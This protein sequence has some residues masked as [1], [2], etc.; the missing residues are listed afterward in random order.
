MASTSLH[1]PVANTRTQA[2][3]MGSTPILLSHTSSSSPTHV[4]T[5]P[6]SQPDNRSYSLSATTS[7]ISDESQQD[8]TQLIPLLTNVMTAPAP[9]PSSPQLMPPLPDIVTAPAPQPCSPGQMPSSLSGYTEKND[10]HFVPLKYDPLDWPTP[11]DVSND[12]H[13][14]HPDSFLPTNLGL[15]KEILHLQSRTLLDHNALD[16]FQHG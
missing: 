13:S 5:L 14:H 16:N 2:V 15:P 9:Q 7:P 6:T 1:D 10:T 11:I 3:I 12:L 8:P 4:T